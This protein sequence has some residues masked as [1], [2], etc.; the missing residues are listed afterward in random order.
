MLSR[1]NLEE[2]K[3]IDSLMRDGNVI[4]SFDIEETKAIFKPRPKKQQEYFQQRI[5]NDSNNM[6]ESEAFAVQQ[7]S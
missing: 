2:T 4:Q 3:Q 6:T 7:I 5:D 1:S